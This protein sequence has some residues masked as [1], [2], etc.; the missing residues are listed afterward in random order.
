MCQLEKLIIF[1]KQNLRPLKKR[2]TL[3]IGCFRNCSL[4]K[5]RKIKGI[6]WDAQRLLWVPL[7]AHAVPLAT[8]AMWVSVPH[9][10]TQTNMHSPPS[11]CPA[12]TVFSYSHSSRPHFL[13][14]STECNRTFSFTDFKKETVFLILHYLSSFCSSLY[15]INSSP[16]R[17]GFSSCTNFEPFFHSKFF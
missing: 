9:P 13:Q 2:D 15:F 11:L 17:N 8:S 1:Q 3:E 6:P 5:G 14:V 4:G 10:H 7:K 16:Q 12:W